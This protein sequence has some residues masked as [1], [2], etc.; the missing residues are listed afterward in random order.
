MNTIPADDNGGQAS[1]NGANRLFVDRAKVIGRVAAYLAFAFALTIP[2]CWIFHY[3]ILRPDIPTL[4]PAHLIGAFFSSLLALSMFFLFRNQANW[5]VKIIWSI[6]LICSGIL[7][8]EYATPGELPFAEQIRALDPVDNS[9]KIAPNGALCLFFAS[10]AALF[11]SSKR[12]RSWHIGQVMAVTP[13][14]VA[15]LA[16]IGH[17]YSI[18]SLY[19]I[20]DYSQMSVPGALNN[21]F[22]AAALLCVRPAEGIMRILV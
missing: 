4:T 19:D 13:A 7:I 12:I 3:P 6:I 17:A 20:S 2:A 8:V 11:I 14:I 9:D 10:L 16:I 22:L 18:E 15:S 1:L 21:F 5:P